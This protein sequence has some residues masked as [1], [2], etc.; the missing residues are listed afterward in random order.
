MLPYVNAHLRNASVFSVDAARPACMSVQS[1]SIL[2][3]GDMGTRL[4][5]LKQAFQ[6]SN[7]FFLVI[8]VIYTF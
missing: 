6:F 1:T 4:A 8:K 7:T 2:M 5:G 3:R